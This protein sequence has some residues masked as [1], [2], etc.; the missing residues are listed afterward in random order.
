M[1]DSEP[2]TVVWACVSSSE[3]VSSMGR[4][5]NAGLT[6]DLVAPSKHGTGSATIDQ[7]DCGHG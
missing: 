6:V 3:S 1:L 5:F 2:E 7:L 4:Q